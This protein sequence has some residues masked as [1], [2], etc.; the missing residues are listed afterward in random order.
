MVKLVKGVMKTLVYQLGNQ[1][2]TLNELNTVLHETSNL[3]NSRPLGIKPNSD[4]SSEFLC[5]NSLLLGRNADQVNSGPFNAKHKADQGSV[6]DLERFK[7]VQEITK[8]F[9]EVWTKN[10]FPT[11]LVRKKWH[12]SKRNM[13]VGDLCLLQD[14]NQLRGEFRLVESQMCILTNMEMLGTLKCWLVQS[15]MVQFHFILKVSV[16]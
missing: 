3:V 4:T 13:Q 15:K 7:L 6:T 16:V 9:W 1:V 12:F 10:Y 11:L 5:P 2:L 8:Q 14:A